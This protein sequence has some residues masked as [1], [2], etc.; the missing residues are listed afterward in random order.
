M[1][2]RTFI[3][4]VAAACLIAALIGSVL[5]VHAPYEFDTLPGTVDNSAIVEQ[6]DCGTSLAAN[7][8]LGSLDRQTACDSAVG[9][10]RAWTIPLGVLG[11][12][13]LAGVALVNTERRKNTA[14]RG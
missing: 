11:I 1:N 3:G 4:L 8:H 5:Q 7:D 10:R 13:G 2:V 14:A 9:T 12:I 6:S